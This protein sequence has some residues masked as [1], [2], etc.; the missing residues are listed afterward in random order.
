[1]D[2]YK[3]M[4]TYQPTYYLEILEMQEILKA[5]A[6]ESATEEKDYKEVIANNFMQTLSP[7]GA[8]RWEKILKI[9]SPTTELNERISL[10]ISKLRGLQKLSSTRIKEIAKS[11][12]NGNIEVLFEDSTIIIKYTDVAGVPPN[13]SD[14]QNV[15]E[16][17]KPAH[18]DVSFVFVYLWWDK[19]DSY[20]YEWDKWDSL[21]LTFDEWEL[22]LV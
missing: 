8:S 10:I 13:F 2:F 12:K 15:I 18:L 17:L 14:F 16:Q 11:Y 3:E 1:M 4:Q 6:K 7:W 9:T 21:D 5:N 22:Y 19:F 20:N